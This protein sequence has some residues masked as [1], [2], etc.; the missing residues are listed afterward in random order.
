V[1]WQETL[2]RE[3]PGAVPFESFEQRLRETLI[4]KGV[5]PE[6][7]LF[8]SA[9]CR[10][11]VNAI[12]VR[13]F[14][15]HWGEN[16]ELGGLGGYPTAGRTGFSAYRHHVP[17]DGNMLILYGPHIGISQSGALGQI[18]RA[19]MARSTSCCGALAGYLERIRKDS[20]YTPELELKDIEQGALELVLQP[21]VDQ[22][23]Q[24]SDPLKAMSEKL[25]ERIGQRIDSMLAEQ[26]PEAPIA[27]VGGILINTSSDSGKT[28]AWFAVRHAELRNVGGV[29][30]QWSPI[31]AD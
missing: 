4:E 24:A 16:F 11:E 6:N 1:S 5:R 13:V 29:P 14:E 18:D 21:D 30:G 12:P 25:V 7:T 19:Q 15:Q 17:D 28:D 9:T 20:S 31:H 22:F 23:L 2:Q 3:Y 8:A 26:A 10:D 27:L